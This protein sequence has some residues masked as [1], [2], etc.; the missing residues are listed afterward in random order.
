MTTKW[1]NADW[2]R[3]ARDYGVAYAETDWV[4]GLGQGNA[5]VS[6]PCRGCYVEPREGQG[7][8]RIKMA[9]GTPASAVFGVTL[10][11]SESDEVDKV[12]NPII[13]GATF[14]WVPVS[15]VNQL[16]FYCAGGASTVDIM[17]FVG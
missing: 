13:Q 10:G 12:G 7:T 8:D 5:G 3:L 17:Y 1:D 11:V 6:I 9:V 14:L 2:S 4:T 15:D 16:Y